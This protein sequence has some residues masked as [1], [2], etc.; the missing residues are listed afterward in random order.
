MTEC[1]NFRVLRSALVGLGVLLLTAIAAQ[2]DLVDDLSKRLT[3]E[4][5]TLKNGMQVVVIPDHRVP[6][7]THM[8]WYKTGSADEV[9]GKSGI[10]H[11]LEHLMFKGTKKI[12]P[13][14][15][16]KIIARNG[17][18]GNAFTSSDYTAYYQRIALDRLPLLMEMESDRMRNLVLTDDIV[19]PERDVVIEE[20]N[21]RI[22][23]SP[24]ALLAEQLSAALFQNH[25]YGVPVIGWRHELAELTRQDALAFYRIYYAPNN[26]TLIVAGDIDAATLRPLTEK[27]Y[28]RLKPSKLPPRIR[29]T[30]PPHVAERRVTLRDGR[31]RQP[32]WQRH[33]LAPSRNNGEAG[34]SPSLEVLQYVLGGHNNSRLYRRLVIEEKLAAAASASYSA[35]AINSATFAISVSPRPGASLDRIEIIVDEEIQKLLDA[36]VREAEVRGA[37]KTIINDTIFALDN[38]QTM[39]QIFGQVLS[40]GGSISDVTNWPRT[41]A[42]VNSESVNQV[43]AE[44]L[45]IER[46]VTGRLLPSDEEGV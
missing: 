43:A 5:F 2:A 19:L 36:G 39:A 34:Q 44:V 38:Q 4:T 22:E 13:G 28:G 11:F 10:A 33:Y 26:A 46:S 41:I 14:E 9:Q 23:N 20:R 15:F 16:S 6:V 31:V 18:Q 1:L 45:K 40:G 32:S 7:V 30:E 3:P 25:R 21:T 35:G 37:T 27:Y 17:G 12:P 8:V 29:A 42:E 24:G